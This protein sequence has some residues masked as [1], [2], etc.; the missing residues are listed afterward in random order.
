MKIIPAVSIK[1]GRVVVVENGKYAYLKGRDGQYQSPVQ[2][3]K[4][5]DTPGDEIFVLDIDGLERNSPDLDTVKRM[6]AYRD[7]WLDAGAED[8][9][10][11]MD[12]F[13]SD[14]SRVV[15]GTIC[16][17]S[18]D[19]LGKALDISENVIFSM[20]YDSGIVSPNAGIAGMG[21]ERLM[22]EIED[23]HSL[24]T[25]L[26]FDLGG[27][28][29]GKAPGIPAMPGIAER[30]QEFYVSGHIT[31]ADLEGLEKAGATGVIMDF[32]N[33]GGVAVEGS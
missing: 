27:I 14:A 26:F 16:M 15:M 12:L 10:S 6:A 20:G 13:I 33:V 30:F 24:R 23:M 18:L 31:D 22:S 7:V 8:A 4:E 32:R 17:R 28:R 9:D 21:L 29:D 19:E 3:V 25:G 1:H 5:L 2:L 11:M